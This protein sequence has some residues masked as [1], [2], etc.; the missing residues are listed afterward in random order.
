MMD[1]NANP[2]SKDDCSWQVPGMAYVPWQMFTKT[3]DPK[4]ALMAGTIFPELDKPFT[5]KCI[6]QNGGRYR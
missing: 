1:R 4:Q 2:M 3:Y 5:G 6:M